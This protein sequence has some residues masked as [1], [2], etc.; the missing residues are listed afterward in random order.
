MNSESKRF[1][2]IA[3]I[4]GA[5][6]VGLGAFGA[7]ALKATLLENGR[8]ATYETAVLYHFIH[9]LALLGVGILMNTLSN[10][11]LTRAAWCFT[12]GMVIFS[13][14]LYVLCLSG[15]TF[16]GAITPIGGVLFILGWLFLFY[17]VVKTN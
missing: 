4:A 12:I 13:G 5:L 3:S 6:A 14:S 16:L 7:H 11:W 17:G 9:T 15:I 1:I 10:P 2:G 8:L